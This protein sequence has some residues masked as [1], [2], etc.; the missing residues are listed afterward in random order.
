MSE[1]CTVRLCVAYPK[2]PSNGRRRFAQKLAHALGVG[3]LWERPHNELEAE[4][5]TWHS[6]CDTAGVRMELD[7]AMGALSE[8]ERKSLAGA[9]LSYSVCFHGAGYGDDAGG[10][11]ELTL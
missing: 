3:E 6:Y 2:P 7:A 10:C 5:E 9:T 8:C 4:H 1:Y 11:V